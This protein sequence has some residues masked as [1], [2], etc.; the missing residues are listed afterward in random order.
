[1][2][3]GTAPQES[4]MDNY[5]VSLL[6][7]KRIDKSFDNIKHRLIIVFDRLISFVDQQ[8]CFDYIE[9]S[10]DISAPVFVIFFH[11]TDTTIPTI[12][13]TIKGIYWMDSLTLPSAQ[14]HFHHIEQLI[15]V[16][17]RDI[18]ALINDFSFS[19]I[20]K[21]VRPLDPM[22]A[23]YTSLMAFLDV[24]ISLTHDD[25]RQVAQK[26]FLTNS[27]AAYI[28]N[29]AQMRVIDRFAQEYQSFEQAIGWYTRDSFVYR[30][31]NR[32]L[33][34]QNPDIIHKYRFFINDPM[35][36]LDTLHQG[37]KRASVKE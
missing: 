13:G 35:L 15:S 11:Y 8:A 1:M 32:A 36:H 21:S 3:F 18:R 10:I 19:I 23:S 16:L 27:R 37:E 5:A 33:H 14:Q 6:D 7:R 31:V 28:N 26:D 29:S 25:D 22:H 30:L 20:Q 9:S 17:R 2:G 24:F 12:T 4:T 34:S